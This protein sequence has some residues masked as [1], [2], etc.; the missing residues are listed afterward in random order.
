MNLDTGTSVK[1]KALTE[2]L[3]AHPDAALHFQLPDGTRVPPHFHVTEVGGV[4]K[5]FIDCGG[6]VRSTERCVLQLWTADD[7]GHRLVASKLARIIKL[8]VRLLGPDDLAVE[9]EYDVGVITQFRVG[10][11][12]MTPDGI[13]FR[14]EG[15]HTACLAQERCGIGPIAPAGAQ[16]CGSRGSPDLSP[17]L[18]STHLNKSGCPL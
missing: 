15:K 11:A 6:T 14:L 10:G 3:L 7:D 18:P 9:V 4:R 5:D 13:V 8:G 17:F 16:C 1:L 2:F 12:A